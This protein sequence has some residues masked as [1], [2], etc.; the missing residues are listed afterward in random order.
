MVI[1][2]NDLN[3]THFRKKVSKMRE[4]ISMGIIL[5]YMIRVR[6]TP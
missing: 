1:K 5:K 6:E 2:L 3:H 4:K